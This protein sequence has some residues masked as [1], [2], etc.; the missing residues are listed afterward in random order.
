MYNQ[1]TIS[2]LKE[3]R[4]CYLTLIVEA[5]N[6]RKQLVKNSAVFSNR[7]SQN[8]GIA[9]KGGGR[10]DPCQDLFGGFDIV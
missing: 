6:K 8:L 5:E 1:K 2:S 9:K 10:S 3:R 7:R 4:L